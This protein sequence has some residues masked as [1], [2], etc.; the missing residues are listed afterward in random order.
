MIQSPASPGAYYNIDNK[1]LALREEEALK[2]MYINQISILQTK[3]G[4]LA[5]KDLTEIDLGYLQ[6]YLMTLRSV[7]NKDKDMILLNLELKNRFNLT[8]LTEQSTTTKNT[9]KKRAV[10][11]S[12]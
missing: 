11:S 10:F 5:K 1:I 2:S 9:R 6:S 7:T 8:V 4:I 12:N 3:L